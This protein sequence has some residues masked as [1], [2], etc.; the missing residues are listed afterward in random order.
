M[1]G[2]VGTFSQEKALVGADCENRW[3]VCSST[4]YPDLSYG[5]CT[6]TLL[7]PRHVLTAAHCL[8]HRDHLTL[9]LG[10]VLVGTADKRTSSINVE[11][12][13]ARADRT[14]QRTIGMNL[15]GFHL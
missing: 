10:R 7:D 8:A 2:L 9:P 14:E 5:E 12:A 13:K 3:I 4:P 15:N 11:I 6:G 1:K